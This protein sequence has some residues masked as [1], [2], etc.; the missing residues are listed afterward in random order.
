MEIGSLLFGLLAFI[1]IFGYRKLKTIKQSRP[2]KFWG[3][4]FLFSFLFLFGANELFRRVFGGFAGSYPF[5]EAWNIA[6]KEEDVINAIRELKDKNPNLRI[7]NDTSFRRSYWFYVNFYY[8]D[9]KQTV[10]AW[11]R[12]GRNEFTTDLAFI[13]LSNPDKNEEAKLINKDFWYWSN[14]QEINK[15]KTQIVD[16]LEQIIYSKK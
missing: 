16:K 7:Q 14:R 3:V 13:S 2:F 5:V 4:I 9:T 15:F 8:N 11:T 10:H 6:A 1:L 12:P